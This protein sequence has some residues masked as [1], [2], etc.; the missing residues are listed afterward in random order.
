MEMI[1]SISED[2]DD[3]YVKMD[4]NQF[5]KVTEESSHVSSRKFSDNT[6]RTTLS[7]VTQ[8][9]VYICNVPMAISRIM[10]C[11]TTFVSVGKSLFA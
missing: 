8:Q 9:Q 3:L 11:Q 5:M 2:D 1:E 7:P 4:Y 6:K 10:F